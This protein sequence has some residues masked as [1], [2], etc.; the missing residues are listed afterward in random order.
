MPEA[1]ALLE[2]IKKY[3]ILYANWCD[4]GRQLWEGFPADKK[5][6]PR[7]TVKPTELVEL[8]RPYEEYLLT[9]LVIDEP[10]LYSTSDETR[11]W[12]E[13]MKAFYPYIPVQMNNTVM[14]IPS[15]FA[16]LKTDILMLAI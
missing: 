16:D 5:K 13:Y 11:S 15:K 4:Y 14:G 10:E 12:L 8:I 1:K 3:N 2:A 7:V 6:D 9:N